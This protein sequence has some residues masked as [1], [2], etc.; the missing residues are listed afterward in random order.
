[1][2]SDAAITS[3]RYTLSGSLRWRLLDGVWLVHCSGSGATLAADPVDAALLEWLS[4]G[5]ASAAGLTSRL[6]LASQ[7]ELPPDIAQGVEIRLLSWLQQGW[8]VVMD[9]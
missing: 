6:G 5:P 8:L 2:A 1:M 9:D 4:D 3:C 7:A